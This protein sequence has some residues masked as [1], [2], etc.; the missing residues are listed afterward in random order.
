MFMYIVFQLHTCKSRP[1][2]VGR[3]LFRGWQTTRNCNVATQTGSTYISG[4]R[5]YDRYRRY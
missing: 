2:Q 1:L 4:F 5:K 3:Q